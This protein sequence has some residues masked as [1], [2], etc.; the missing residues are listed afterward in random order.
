[1]VSISKLWPVKIVNFGKP[2]KNINIK[3][4]LMLSPGQVV[5][6]ASSS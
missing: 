6:C 3:K 1:M 5:K 4:C 2:P